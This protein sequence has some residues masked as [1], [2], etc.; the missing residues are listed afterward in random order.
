[1]VCRIN[2]QRIV[3]KKILQKIQILQENQRD[4]HFLSRDLVGYKQKTQTQIPNS[5]ALLVVTLS[6]PHWQEANTGHLQRI[7]DRFYLLVVS[8]VGCCLL[9]VE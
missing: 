4:L 7:G 5:P 6:S 3:Q 1:M 9:C 8:R 2:G